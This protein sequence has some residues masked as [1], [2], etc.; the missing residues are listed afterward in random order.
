MEDTNQKEYPIHVRT[1]FFDVTLQG[2]DLELQCTEQHLVSIY[3]FFYHA[4][5]RL[6]EIEGRLEVYRKVDGVIYA[7]SVDSMTKYLF[8]KLKELELLD[9]ALIIDVWD[10]FED[11]DCIRK[12]LLMEHCLHPKQDGIKDRHDYL[13]K[14][15]SIYRAN[16]IHE[17]MLRFFRKNH[18]AQV[19]DMAGLYDSESPLFFKE[20]KDGQ[21]LV[22][23][24]YNRHGACVSMTGYDCWLS[25]KEPDEAK[26]NSF[27]SSAHT[28]VKLDFDPLQDM[29]LLDRYL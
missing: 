19:G 9:E 21:Y 28:E 7:E 4:G 2:I 5:F 3:K 24:H 1:D 10:Y 15:D 20:L 26:N 12:D 29:A 13:L 23:L 17:T 27:D 6:L 8:D 16:F 22:F 14:F 18:F 25:K 11:S